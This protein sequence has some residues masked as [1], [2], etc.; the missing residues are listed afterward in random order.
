MERRVTVPETITPYRRYYIYRTKKGPR[1]IYNVMALLC[2]PYRSL[3]EAK[4]VIDGVR[5][6]AE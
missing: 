5:Q 4:R 6:W 2:G 1:H 3:I